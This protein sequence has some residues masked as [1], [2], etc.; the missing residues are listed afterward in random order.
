MHVIPVKSA[1]QV[2]LYSK[3]CLLTVCRLLIGFYRDCFIFGFQCTQHYC[4]KYAGGGTGTALGMD[5]LC[6]VCIILLV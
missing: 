2:L 6:T 1:R 4:Y 5:L 3:V